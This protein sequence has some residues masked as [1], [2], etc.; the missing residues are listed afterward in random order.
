MPAGRVR[1]GA[2]LAVALVMT[3]A[4]GAMPVGATSQPSAQGTASAAAVGDAPGT[5]PS[6]LAESGI[7]TGMVGTGWTVTNGDTPRPFRVRILGTLRD[8]IGPGRD[9]IVIKVSDLPGQHVI[10]QGGGIWAGM[11]GSPVYLGSKLAGAVSYGFSNGPS[12]IGGM[13]PAGQMHRIANYAAASTSDRTSVRLSASMRATVAQESGVSATSRSSLHR[14]A[15]PVVVTAAPGKLR[16]RLTSALRQE[17]GNIKVLAG[18]G[19]SASSTAGLAPAPVPGGNLAAVIASGD[20]TVAA[21]GTATSVCGDTVLG[22][23][24]PFT[25]DGK[26]AFGAAR[27]RS[28]TIVDDPAGTP[29]K[30]A[31]IGHMFGLLDQDRQSGIRARA[32]TAPRDIAVSARVRASDS[33]F[34]RVGHTSVTTSSWVP[35]VAANHLLYDII[36]TADSEGAGTAGLTWTIKG[37]RPNGQ[38]WTLVRT[39]RVAS[40]GV[41]ALASAQLLL[42]QL[43]EIDETAIERVRFDSVTMQATVSPIVKQYVVESALVSRNGGPWKERTSITA[44]PGDHLR[45]KVA[46]KIWKGATTSTIVGLTVPASATGSGFLTIGATP[47]GGGSDCGFDPSACP[48]TFNALLQSIRDA[49]RGDDLP[50]TLDLSAFDPQGIQITKVKHL[51]KVVDGSI[52]FPIDVN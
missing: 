41:V 46:L 32:G 28:L 4:S 34:G 3:A 14:L 20:I 17:L 5:C 38:H 42:D 47:L 30:L 16:N 24:H 35:I 37:T 18:S 48:T 12:R 13:T 1:V 36:A 15:V 51:D 7:Q 29:F 21:V 25:G 31:N 43:A 50:V 33:G 11:S 23:G 40:T 39:D 45:F 19:V 22:F 49:P 8:G 26:V 44:H 6:L 52:E 9:L 27:A 10:S 2:G